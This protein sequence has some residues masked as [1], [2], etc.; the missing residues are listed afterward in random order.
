MNQRLQTCLSEAGYVK[1][2]HFVRNYLTILRVF[3]RSERGC[4]HQQCLAASFPYPFACISAPAKIIEIFRLCIL[5][6]T[7]VYGG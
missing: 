1:K 4:S 5:K 6:Q 3:R 2:L 7:G